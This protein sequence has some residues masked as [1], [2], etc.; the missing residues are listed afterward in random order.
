MKMT[1]AT[2]EQHGRSPKRVLQSLNHALDLIDVV[3]VADRP[4]GTTELA[5]YTG[6]SKGAVH[7]LLAN[8]EARQYLTRD[9]REA[10]FSLGSRLWELGRKAGERMAIA[11][12][13]RPAL[14]D[15]TTTTGEN[16]HVATYCLGGEVVFLDRVYSSHPVQVMIVPIGQRA[17][18]PTTALGH[19]LL[20]H[21]E[22]AEIDRVCKRSLRSLTARSIT[23]PARLKA[24]LAEVRHEGYAIARGIHHEDVVAVA[25]PVRDSTGGVVAAL[26]VF[27]PAYRFDGAKVTAMIPEVVRACAAVSARLGHAGA[28]KPAM[29][30]P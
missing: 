11:D 18:A 6:L 4:M 2:D 1:F 17:P 23:T 15:L 8:L 22:I 10:V 9:P 13:A 5:A 27:G 24:V 7:A 28:A 16:S 25:A 19:V 12:V 30:N 26:G 29:R 21:Q 14:D 20:A 3:A